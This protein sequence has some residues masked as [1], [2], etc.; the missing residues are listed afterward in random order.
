VIV[1]D[2]GIKVKVG[3]TVSH[4]FALEFLNPFNDSFL[5]LP[6]ATRMG[7]VSA[8]KEEALARPGQY[9][10]IAEILNVSEFCLPNRRKLDFCEMFRTGI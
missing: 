5:L 9:R 4:Q 2:D 6:F 7:N 1:P 10:A 3:L 8:N